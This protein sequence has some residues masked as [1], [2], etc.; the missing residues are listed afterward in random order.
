[1]L[2]IVVLISGN[3][4]NLQAIIDDIHDDEIDA[5][6][7]AVISNTKEAY[8]LTRAEQAGIDAIV[9]DGQGAALRS[10]YDQQLQQQIDK[11]HPDLVVL[12]GF[13]RILSDDFVNHYH[14][15]I[16]NIHPS[17]L[18]KYQ[19]LNTHQRVLDARDTHHGA[20]VHFVIPE[21]DAGPLILQAE[22]TVHDNDTAETLAQRVHQQ[23]HIIYPL[24]IKWFAE[25]RVNMVN[26]KTFKDGEELTADAAKLHLI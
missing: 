17:L 13:M 8:G 22:V 26:N 20:S 21:L 15:K 1:M 23:E 16:I 14:G 12:A 7:V 25:G 24:V 9:I 18:P 2:R 5:S 4:S 3:G 11:Y 6:V 19:G 10:Q